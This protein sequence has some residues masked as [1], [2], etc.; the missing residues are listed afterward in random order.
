MSTIKTTILLVF[1]CLPALAQAQKSTTIP[2]EISPYGLIFTEVTIN[3]KTVRAMIDFGQPHLLMVSTSLIHEQQIETRDSKKRGYDINGNEMAFRE[4]E[5][6]ELR[7]QELSIKTVTFSS[8]PN[9]MESVSQQIGTRFDAALGW[10]FFSKYFFTLD[11]SAEKITL[12]SKAQTPEGSFEVPYDKN[13]SYMMLNT[14]LGKQ[15]AKLIIDTGAPVS[16]LHSGFTKEVATIK[17]QYGQPTQKLKTAIGPKKLEVEYELRD[18]S[19]LKPLKVVGIIGG[20]LLKQYTISIN[21]Q[22]QT[23]HWKRVG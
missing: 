9:E 1:L 14:K 17:N 8:V 2:F 20:D 12:H 7:V 6:N 23:M 16:T 13:G 15:A 3:G 11:Y 4:G 10:G 19:V 5:V 22:A 21:P 18:L